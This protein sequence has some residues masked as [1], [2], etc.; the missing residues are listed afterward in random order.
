[1]MFGKV[2]QAANARWED[3]PTLPEYIDDRGRNMICFNHICGRC[4]FRPCR[5]RKGH[6]P[7]EKITDDWANTLWK[8]IELGIKYNLQGMA[9][10]SDSSSPLKRQRT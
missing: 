1:M 10:T 7:K 3:L 5:L 2:L 9:P 6:V 4:T 8:K